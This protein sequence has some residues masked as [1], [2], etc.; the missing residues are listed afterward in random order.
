MAGRP[1]TIPVRDISLG[2]GTGGFDEDGLSGD[3][4][5]MVVIVPGSTPPATAVMIGP[6]RRPAAGKA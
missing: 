2:R 1:T 4:A 6:L 3:E 5:L